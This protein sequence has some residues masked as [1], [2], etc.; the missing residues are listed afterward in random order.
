MVG[1]ILPYPITQCN[2]LKS[3]RQTYVFL[4]LLMLQI[5]RILTSH[6]CIATR[7]SY[8]RMPATAFAG[9]Q[10]MKDYPRHVLPSTIQRWVTS[11]NMRWRKWHM[12]HLRLVAL[13]SSFAKSRSSQLPIFGCFAGHPTKTTPESATSP[14]V[15]SV[16]SHSIS[17]DAPESNLDPERST[18][19]EFNE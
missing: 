6:L 15:S 11:R 5:P 16:C 17:I 8:V 10:K 13:R 1:Q 12:G 14:E 2:T 4:F 19:K 18:A 7:E 9:G 3:P